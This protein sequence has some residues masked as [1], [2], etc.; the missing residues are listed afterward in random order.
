MAT[1]PCEAGAPV[2]S[3]ILPPRMTMSCIACPLPSEMGSRAFHTS[4]GAG[5]REVSMEHS[6]DANDDRSQV[7]DRQIDLPGDGHVIA[8]SRTSKR[9]RPETFDFLPALFSTVGNWRRL[10]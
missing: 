8:K 1:S 3:T 6:G 5:R 7:G 4:M 10:K 2:P 9:V